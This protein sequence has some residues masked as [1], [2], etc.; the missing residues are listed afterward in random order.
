MPSGSGRAARAGAGAACASGYTRR[1]STKKMNTSSAA[2]TMPALTAT[3]IQL[4]K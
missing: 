2:E 4:G 3:S 1:C